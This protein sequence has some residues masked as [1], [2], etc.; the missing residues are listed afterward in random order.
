[1][2]DSILLLNFFSIF[3]IF[4]NDVSFIGGEQEVTVAVLPFFHIYA[5]NTIMTLG[6]QI[7]AKLVTLPKFEPEA[8]IKALA[9]YKVQYNEWPSLSFFSN[10]TT[11]CATMNGSSTVLE[12]KRRSKEQERLHCHP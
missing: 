6:L 7:G 12:H 1:M 4:F 2:I 9:T 5:M 11:D 8:Y 10:R 3:N